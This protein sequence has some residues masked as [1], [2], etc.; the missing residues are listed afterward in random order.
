MRRSDK[1]ALDCAW[2]VTNENVRARRTSVG[3]QEKGYCSVPVVYDNQRLFRQHLLTFHH[4]QPRESLRALTLVTTIMRA[5]EI[6]S[7][8]ELIICCQRYNGDCTRD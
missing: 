4:G 8:N 5:R 2:Q 1:H 3:D 6:D 7:E